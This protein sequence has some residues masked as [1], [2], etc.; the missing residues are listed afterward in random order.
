MN[1]YCCKN[2]RSNNNQNRLRDIVDPV[3]WPDSLAP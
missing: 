1:D 3:L 2:D